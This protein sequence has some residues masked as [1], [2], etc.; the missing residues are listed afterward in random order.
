MTLSEDAILTDNY[1]KEELS[2]VYLS[3][4]CA[5]AGYTCQ[6]G[7]TPDVDSI[8]ASVKSG[9]HIRVQIDVQLKST[10]SPDLRRGNLHFRLRRKNYNDLAAPRQIPIILAV[11][12]LPRSQDEWLSCNADELI[13]RRRLWWTSIMGEQQ[14][15]AGSKTVIIPESQSLTPDSL[16]DLAGNIRERIL[17]S[18]RP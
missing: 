17:E 3:A 8:D 10:S 4:I 6:R 2:F 7:P 16:S 1:R 5:V 11:L 18:M 14:I 9:G 15:S 13:L 12:E